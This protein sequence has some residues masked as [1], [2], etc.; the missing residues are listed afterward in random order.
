MGYLRIPESCTVEESGVGDSSTCRSKC[1]VE[2]YKT[3]GMTP[4]D[5]LVD[6][7]ALHWVAT[8]AAGI[9]VSDSRRNQNIG[10]CPQAAGAC[11]A[12]HNFRPDDRLPKRW[13]TVSVPQF[14]SIVL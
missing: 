1:P 14:R 9:L 6:T 2:L 8:G 4:Y 12:V 10:I 13:G 3:R 5:V 11:T 7:K